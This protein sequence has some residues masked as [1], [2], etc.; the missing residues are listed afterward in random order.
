MFLHV[1]ELIQ[2]RGC[3]AGR[4]RFKVAYAGLYFGNWQQIVILVVDHAV[5]WA[6]WLSAIHA[7]TASPSKDHKRLAGLC[8]EIWNTDLQ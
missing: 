2:E 8:W 7:A 1:P 5:M 3:N 6:I 4:L